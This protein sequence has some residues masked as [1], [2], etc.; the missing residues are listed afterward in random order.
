MSKPSMPSQRSTG[1]NHGPLP[2]ALQPSVARMYSY[3]LGGKDHYAIDRAAADEVTS[4]LPRVPE[5]A[6]ENRGF[7]R[8]AVTYL[9]SLGIEQ[10]LDFGTGLPGPYAVHDVAR[11]LVPS[12]RVVYS[13]IEPGVV[14]QGR[15]LLVE[16]DQTLMVAADLRDPASLFEVDT[17]R[18]LIDI[19][20]PVAVL[21][22]AV[23]HFLS[24]DDQPGAVMADI[25]SRLPAGSHVVISHATA[26]SLSAKEMQ[27]AKAV[28][29]RAGGAHP[30]SQAEI[31]RLC[32]GLRLVSPGLVPARDWRPD[33]PMTVDAETALGADC[34][35]AVGAVTRLRAT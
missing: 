8:R 25:I 5:L 9:A 21:L 1:A 7:L 34:L 15:A 32:T 29:E 23:L 33:S 27:G 13:D 19:D 30:R 12:A 11:K 31:A 3:W 26:G 35:A 17:V 24:P 20:Q 10:Y 28:Y 22:V 6:V 2:E 4:E 14:A 16:D 18:R